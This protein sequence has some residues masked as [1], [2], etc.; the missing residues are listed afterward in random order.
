MKKI[1]PELLTRILST[2]QFIPPARA[3]TLGHE[4]TPTLVEG[5]GLV[6]PA[7]FEPATKGL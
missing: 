6:R 5:R 1:L 4:K 7:G 2:R 3:S